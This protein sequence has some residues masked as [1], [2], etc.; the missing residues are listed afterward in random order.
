MKSNVSFFN[1]LLTAAIFPLLF[2]C[3]K[4]ITDNQA[5]PLLSAAKKGSTVTPLGTTPDVYVAGSDN[6]QAVYWKNG[7]ETVLTG[8]QTAT[9]IVV[10]GSGNVYV[11]GYGHSATTGLFVAQ[12]WLNGTLTT[13]S[14]GTNNVL[15]EGIALYGTN[16]YIVGQEGE[17]VHTGE[18]WTNGVAT[19]LG[20]GQPNGIFIDASGNIYIPNV[21]SS[22]T[23]S[24]W[25]NGT[26][27][28]LTGG[29][30]IQAIAVS[31]TTVYGVG[32]EYG[33]AGAETML[34]WTN[35]SSQTLGPAGTNTNAMAVALTA[36]GVPVISGTIVG[37]T[38]NY[39]IGYWS[40]LGDPDILGTAEFV[41]ATTGIAVDGTGDVF[42]CGS[43][44]NSSSTPVAW[45][46]EIPSTGSVVPVQLTNGTTS[47]TALAIALGQ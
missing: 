37:S 1:L 11:C 20:S 19:S 14:D 17:F 6:G 15:A 5:N 28:T 4:G 27:V 40:A 3:Q 10:D 8:G 47:A 44:F 13:L 21:I 33:S 45:Y 22:N 32:V 39:Q 43:Q 23:P 7:T 41:A 9:G 36:S 42:V 26:L 18:Y 24:Y 46:W 34:L 16:V 35:S 2:G 29:G 38:G 30:V 12:Y 31:G 25:K